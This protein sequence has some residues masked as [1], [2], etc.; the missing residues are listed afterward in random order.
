MVGKSVGN[1]VG[2]LVKNGLDPGRPVGSHV[3]DRVA[4]GDLARWKQSRCWQLRLYHAL[5][6]LAATVWLDLS[7]IHPHTRSVFGVPNTGPSNLS[8]TSIT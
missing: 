7:D 4:A 6:V 8:G 3:L 2:K 5:D 1:V